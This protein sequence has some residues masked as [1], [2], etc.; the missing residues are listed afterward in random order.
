[1]TTRT[2]LLAAAVALLGAAPPAAK[3]VDVAIVTTQGTIVV[4]IETAKAPLTS[5]NFLRYVDSRRY[6]GASFYRTVRAVFGE[7]VPRIQVVQGGLGQAPGKT[8]PPIPVEPT[9]RTGLHNVEGSL[10]MARNAEPNSA[11]SEFFVN[12]ADDRWLDA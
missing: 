6:D 9:T 2:F 8:F 5:K 11:T 1:M 10:A 3:P 7:P 4:R 12:V